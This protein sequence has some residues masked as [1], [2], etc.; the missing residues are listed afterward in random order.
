[1]SRI[2]CERTVIIGHALSSD[3]AALKASR[4]SF[5]FQVLLGGGCARGLSSTGTVLYC[6]VLY[7]VSYCIGTLGRGSV[8]HTPFHAI[9]RRPD[10]TLAYRGR[11]RHIMIHRQGCIAFK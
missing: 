3:L 8:F 6:T 2:C 10:C 9:D 5:R 4:R 11:I 7:R 1:M